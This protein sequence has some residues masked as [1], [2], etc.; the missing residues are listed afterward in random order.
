MKCHKK[1]KSL[2]ST[3]KKR[4]F[5]NRRRE[6]TDISEISRGRV[7]SGECGRVETSG[8]TVRKKE[9]MVPPKQRGEGEEGGN[10]PIMKGDLWCRGKHSGGRK[11]GHVRVR[12]G[13]K[14]LHCG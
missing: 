13:G 5:V 9:S 11:K 2:S 12:G 14:L 7:C 8:K 4:N 10:C 3:K 1:K 6:G